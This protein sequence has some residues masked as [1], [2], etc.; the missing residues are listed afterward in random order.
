MAAVVVL[1]LMVAAGMTMPAYVALR[2]G[3]IL[4]Y[5]ATML[6]LPPLFV[7]LAIANAPKIIQTARGRREHFKR[8]PKLEHGHGFDAD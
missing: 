7:Y 1:T 2:R 5:F 4:K 3:P 8:T 6:L